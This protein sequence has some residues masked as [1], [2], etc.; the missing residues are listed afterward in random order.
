MMIKVEINEKQKQQKKI[1]ETNSWFLEI[2]KVEK[3]LA[4][5]IRRKGKGMDY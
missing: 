4:R 2:S 1:S 5:L 3:F